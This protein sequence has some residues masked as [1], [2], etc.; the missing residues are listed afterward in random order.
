M[1]ISDLSSDVCSSDLPTSPFG[2]FSLV[3]SPLP[4]DSLDGK[5]ALLS[6]GVC[7]F[8]VKIQ[9]VQDAGGIGV[10]VVNREPGILIMDQT[11]NPV[12]PNIRSA[13]RSYGK[14][15]VS[16]RSTLWTRAH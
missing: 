8:T 1:R 10:I 15:C 5:I 7:D 3:C 11:D 13:E 14:E 6:R 4:A 9:N 12:Q 2:G 16:R